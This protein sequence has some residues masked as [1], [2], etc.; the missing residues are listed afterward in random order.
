MAGSGRLI[1]KLRREREGGW[2][3][4]GFWQYVLLQA[5][6]ILAAA[7][8]LWVAHAWVGLSTG[9]AIA[10]FGGWVLK[11][12]AMYPLFRVL[13]ASPQVGPETLIGARGIVATPLAPEGQVQLRGELWRAKMAR[14]DETLAPGTPVT[15]RDVQGLTLIV[16][17]NSASN[18]EVQGEGGYAAGR[19]R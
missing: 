12:L 14:P 2:L 18:P 17:G 10:L 5:P 8:I 4:R 9:W 13:F 1:L 15:V 3:T 6:D 7:V 11:D 16:H 19:V